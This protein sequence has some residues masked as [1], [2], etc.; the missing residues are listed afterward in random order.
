MR[1]QLFVGTNSF[2]LSICWPD[3]FS[4]PQF[5]LALWQN[6]KGQV[7]PCLTELKPLRWRTD[8]RISLEYFKHRARNVL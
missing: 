1:E 4:N 7:C 5:N 3:F 8:A 6:R 2:T